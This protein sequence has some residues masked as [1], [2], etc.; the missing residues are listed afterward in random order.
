MVLTVAGAV[1]RLWGLGRQGL[2]YDE[3]LTA[4]ATG[5]GLRDL[6][7]HVAHVEGIGPTYFVAMWGWAQVFGDS[8]VSLRF[9]SVA[10]GVA[11]IPV[12]YAA[13]RAL[14]QRRVTG[15]VAATIVAVHPLLV[16]YSQEARPYSLL[17]FCGALSLLAY[18]RARDSGSVRDHLLWGGL[19]A[20]TVSIHY[21]A[22]FLFVVEGAALLAASRANRRTVLVGC[23]PLAA[24][25]VALAP[26]AASQRANAGS[27]WI[28]EFAYSARLSDIGTSALVGPSTPEPWLWQPLALVVVASVGLLALAATT[29]ARRA[30][31]LAA[32]LGVGAL[33]LAIVATLVGPDVLVGRYVIAS[34]VPIVVAVAIGL[35]PGLS[36][37]AQLVGGLGVVVFA[38][39]SVFVVATVDTDSGLQKPDWETVAHVVDS[40]VGGEHETRAVVMNLHGH[41][42]LPLRYYLGGADELAAGDSTEVR[43]IDVLVARATSRPCNF[44]VGRACALVFL[45]APLPHPLADRFTLTERVQI[46]QFVIERY[47][48]PRPVAVTRQ[49]ILGAD[50]EQGLVLAVDV[51]PGPGT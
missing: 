43:E 13:A 47:R 24:A 2:W 33:L 40:S 32:G 27:S 48:A 51:G 9:V 34:L 6:V 10:F 41:Q 37:P 11:T 21:F 42:G 30:A 46:D 45:G 28:A 50:G 7:R 25:L 20:V 49:A 26:L 17:A 5:G 22:I 3:W 39:V 19:A 16:W 12:A 23:A 18:A 31:A 15:L 14:G 36:R 4:D 1:L 29:S 44:L 8:E 38:A 35:T